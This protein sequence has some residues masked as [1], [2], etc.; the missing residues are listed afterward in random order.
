MQMTFK[1]YVKISNDL[2][3]SNYNN[4]EKNLGIFL[5]YL[6]K[7][8]GIYAFLEK[9][10]PSVDLQNW[11]KESLNNRANFSSPFPKNAN[12]SLSIRLELLRAISKKEICVV[13]FCLDLMFTRE[14]QLNKITDY[15]IEK[16]VKPTLLDLD[17][18]L[19][20][21]KPFNKQNQLASKIND[22]TT[23][24]ELWYKRPTGIILTTV[25][26]SIVFTFFVSP[27]FTNISNYLAR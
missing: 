10:L 8:K 6:P 13:G 3:S 23:S 4:L 14:Q 19:K 17:D 15:F 20:S 21:Y 16:V 12:E 22:M 24:K 27:L 9:E 2:K 11:Y 25:I 5:E 18:L 26:S 7:L 1:K